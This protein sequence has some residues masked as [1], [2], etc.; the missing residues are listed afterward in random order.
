MSDVVQTLWGF[1]H[2]LRH[3]GVDYGDYIEQLTYLLFLKMADER[4]IDLTR[5]TW[6]DEKGK[7]RTTDCSWPTLESKSGTALTDHYAEVL[8]ILSK[9]PGLLGE[10]FTQATPR[11]TNPVNLK[12]LI[13]MIDEEEWT[14][15]EVDVK[16]AA[17]EG[18]LEKAASEG[19]KG[20]G[21]YFTPRPLIQSIC[22]VMKPDPRGKPDF[23][24]C[25]PA[26]G[27]GG[28]LVNAYEWLVG[29]SKGVFER[30][31]AKRILTKTYY[32]Q[33]LVARPRRLALMNLYL[34]GVEPHIYLGDTIYL[35][36]R[37]ERY[38]VILTN[39][40]FGTKGANQ[41]PERDDFTIETS[42]KQLNFVQH[43]VNTLKPGG[44]AAI[45]LPDNCLFEDK[46]GEVF[47]NVM[48]DCRVHSI[49]RLPRGTFTPYSQGVKANVVF[50]QKGQRTDEVWIYDGRS[51]I[52]G[53]TKKDR[54]LTREHFTEFEKCYGNDPNGRAKRK[55]LGEE[56]RFRR[57]PL[58]A[59]KERN[60][61]LDITWLKD[62]TLEENGDLPEP[63]DLATEA[64]TELEA[65]IDDLRDIV[66]LLEKEEVV[67]K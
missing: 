30:G 22:R 19:K 59:I 5:I 46:A 48:D 14:S 35:P 27:T 40:P 56:G 31:E 52:E 12:R 49:L 67:E 4:E 37:G 34:H 23:K 25:D 53:I 15:M 57:F 10:I 39:P 29:E 45:V 17:F 7:Q 44:R 38:D 3:D 21:Q 33:E 16:G 36:D 2:T 13:S 28:F 18:L 60:Y 58:S 20:A 47:K 55:D 64:I 54:P 41:A 66:E 50:L 51:N 6:Q 9:Q 26:C 62:E 11:L 43:V 61:K 8:R 63:Q 1:C 24:I 65:V 42:N 32:G